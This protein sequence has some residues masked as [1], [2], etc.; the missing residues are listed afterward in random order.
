MSNKYI[1][2]RKKIHSKKELSNGI[3]LQKEQLSQ[4]IR[5][6]TIVGEQ[7]EP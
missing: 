5:M 3:C 4:W 7:K 2:T 1:G 6:M